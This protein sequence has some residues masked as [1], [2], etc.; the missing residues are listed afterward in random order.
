MRLG[1]GLIEGGS[2]ETRPEA[3][4]S[5]TPGAAVLRPWELVRHLPA[6]L[7]GLSLVH[8]KLQR[9]F[10]CSGKTSDAQGIIKGQLPQMPCY[11][12]RMF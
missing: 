4:S 5:G 10:P 11:G 6:P 2:P 12:R 7:P 9:H 1:A 8:E 3:P